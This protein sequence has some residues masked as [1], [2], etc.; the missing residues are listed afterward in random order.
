MIEY[1]HSSIFK[2]AGVAEKKLK[3]NEHDSLKISLDICPWTLSDNRLHHS[4]KKEI[5][6]KLK[7]A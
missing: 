6:E 1:A 2:T 4:M 3:D 5:Y 7:L